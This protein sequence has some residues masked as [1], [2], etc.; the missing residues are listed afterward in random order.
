MSRQWKP[1]FCSQ[2]PQVDED[3]RALFK[4][5]DQLA[6]HRRE[7]DLEDLNGLLDQLLE[8]TFAHFS[9][10]ENAMRIAGYPK[11]AR[12]SEQHEAM[13]KA[14]IE[15]LRTVA[16][17]QVALPTFI[18]H[19]KDSFTYHF[20]TDDMTFVTWEK[21]RQAPEKKSDMPIQAGRS[22]RRGPLPTYSLGPGC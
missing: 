13:R 3:H 19:L 17:G 6:T 20:E 18:Q 1:S 21:A 12:H 16:R 5:L 9:R 4:L 10:E 14:L 22:P 8:Y 7:S 2:D 11:L 15:S